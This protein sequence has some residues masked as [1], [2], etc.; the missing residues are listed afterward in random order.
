M[1]RVGWLRL[2]VVGGVALMLELACR[3]G[4]IKPLTMIPP[5]EM[6]V[7]LAGLARSGKLWPDLEQTLTNV[8]VAFLLS[9]VAGFAA[10]VA[11]HRLPRLRRTLDPL[12]ASW[13]A[14]PFF[15]FYPLL[16]VVFG[17]N[18]LPI[19]V[20]AFLFACVAMVINTLNGIDRIPPVLA[21]VARVHRL[22]RL[23][24]ALRLELP[25]ATPHLLTGVKLAV[26]YSFIGVIAS[27]F[28][29][30]GS[31]LG[32]AIGYAYNNFDTATMYALM[33]FIVTLVTA[34]NM[35]LWAYERRLLARRGKA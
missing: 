8:L 30:S 31:G 12:L 1:S 35:G 17:M 32:Y 3:T 25:S 22:G 27:E 13:Y 33:L 21:K 23:E 4:V 9:V 15:V 19:I 16:V 29:L 10:G 11:I 14:V 18:D 2:A 20:I 6:A 34:I 26:A 28:I 7:A 5:S 24:T